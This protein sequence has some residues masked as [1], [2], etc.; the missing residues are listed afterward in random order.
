MIV[1][2]KKV[3]LVMLDSGREKALRKLKKLGV[4]HLETAAGTSETLTALAEKR[5]YLEKCLFAL[6]EGVKGPKDSSLNEETLWETAGIIDSLASRETAL[7]DE[8][9]AFMREL[10]RLAVLGDF[11]PED[12][13]GM[14]EKGIRIRIYQLS[15]DEAAAFPMEKAFVLSRSKTGTTVALVLKAGEEEPEK[16][17]LELPARGPAAMEEQIRANREEMETI[18]TRLLELAVWRPALKQGLAVLDDE[19]RFEEVRS[20]VGAEGGLI[21]LTGYCPS[22]RVEQLKSASAANG[23]AILVK[24]PEEGDQPPTLM[25]NNRVVRIIQPVFDVLGTI[26]GYREYDISIWFLLF[27]TLFFAMIIGDAA[28]GTLFLGVSIFVNI[29]MKKLPDALKL[30]Y[31]LSVATIVWGAVT[32][33]WFGSEKIASLPFFHRFVYEPLYNFNPLSGDT[34]KI[35][36]FIIGTVHL[37]L[38]H[39]KNIIKQ[40]RHLNALADLGWLSMV[41][42]LYYL[43]LNLAIDPKAYPMPDYALYMVAGGLGFLILFG[44]QERGQNFFKGILKGLSGLFVTFL[45]SI[46]AFSDIISYIRLYAVG[47][48]TLAISQSFNA[49]AGGIGGGVG[50]VFAAIILILGH[51]LNV[52]MALLSVVVHGVRLNML[53]FSGH[54][55]MEWSGIKYEPFRET[56]S[57][58][59]GEVSGGRENINSLR[60]E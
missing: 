52:A 17:P 4:V 6:P 2:M 14:E 34:I 22:S 21:W 1:Q 15:R 37:S 25:E 60:E 29:K 38:A 24:D 42:G 9:L 51:T 45:N 49:M 35:M 54:L 8:N 55:G 39:I 58:S 27:F 31:V 23:W 44:K 41:L 28:Y 5:G 36:C 53:E 56:V 16:V 3:S 19:I 40:R 10:E 13:R 30:F 26:P 47:L 43:V 50:I 7:K 20:G 33:S 11:S 57:S 59:L 48:A 32:G 46:S 12:I 18:R